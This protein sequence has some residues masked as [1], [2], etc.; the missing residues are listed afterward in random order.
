VDYKTD[1]S[2]QDTYIRQ[3][4]WYLHALS[5][6]KGAPARGILLQV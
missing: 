4:R 3:L 1:D 2:N 5:L 6:A